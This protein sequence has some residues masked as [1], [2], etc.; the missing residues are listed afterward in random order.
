MRSRRTRAAILVACLATIV[1]LR[2]DAGVGIERYESARPA[3]AAP[4]MRKFERFTMKHGTAITGERVSPNVARSSGV[5]DKN[6]TPRMI[7]D[8]LDEAHR[9]WRRT[10]N[11]GAKLDVE[12]ALAWTRDNTATAIQ[13]SSLP[14]LLTRAYVTLAMI[15]ADANDKKTARSWMTR[16]KAEIPDHPAIRAK[17]G[18][19]AE[20]LYNEALKA[21]S[22]IA[23][24]KLIIRVSN[25]RARIFVNEVERG[26]E[27]VFEGELPIGEYRIFVTADGVGY[28]FDRELFADA[29]MELKVDWDFQRSFVAT[30]EWVGLIVPPA[31][32][33]KET[34]FLKHASQWIQSTSFYVLSLRVEGAHR[35]LTGEVFTNPIGVER[36]GEILLD[37]AQEDARMEAFAAFLEKSTPSPLIVV[38]RGAIK[39]APKPLPA[40]VAEAPFVPSDGVP[41][42]S[43]G[44]W[45]VGGA[46]LVAGATSFFDAKAGSTD[47]TFIRCKYGLPVGAV[48]LGVFLSGMAWWNYRDY[49]DRKRA[50]RGGTAF[51]APSDHG[52][53]VGY[54]GSF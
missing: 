30:P 17:F 4:V 45:I 43:I 48:G 8:K 39:E 42:Y 40:P 10:D 20:K 16:L 11:A 25:R 9:K 54:A 52:G 3:E 47:C 23:H 18:P 41:I 46:A 26:S 53:L 21:E 37:D 12:Q 15:A 33:A 29:P 1:S 49:R 13:I 14:E 22:A 34:D 7:T 5:K 50:A 36:A 28:R 19:D 6:V 44:A 38:Q 51:I 35:Y 24:V 27:G 31:L 2:V 32:K